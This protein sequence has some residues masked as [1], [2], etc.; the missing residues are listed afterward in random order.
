[1]KLRKILFIL[2]SSFLY[3]SLFSQ[4][5]D[6]KF[7]NI[8]IEDGLSHNNVYTIAQDSKGFMWIGTQSGL[9][10]YNGYSINSY[11]YSAE[12]SCSIIS[13][14][15]GKLMFDSKNRLW[16]GTYR[17]GISLYYPHEDKVVQFLN[18]PD[19]EN[20]LAGN[21]IRALVE[22]KE[23]N[24]W[25][26]TAE[27]GLSMYNETTNNF[28]NYTN[29]AENPNSLVSNNIRGL[30][31]DIEGNIWIGTTV[32][33]SKF[34]LKD[35]TFTN[36]KPNETN[37]NSS[38]SD[39]NT[40]TIYA[41]KSGNVWIGTRN[42]GLNKYNIKTKAFEFFDYNSSDSTSISGSRIQCIFEDSFGKIWIG[43]YEGGVCIYN[44]EAKN[45]IRYQHS[46]DNP[47]SLCYDKIETIIEDKS[48][49]L[50]IGTRGGG[51][52]IVDL[53][54]QKF[55]NLIHSNQNSIPEGSVTAIAIENENIIWIGTVNGLCHY[56]K[57]TNEFLTF[58]E[59]EN[60]PNSLSNSRIRSLVSDEKG[61]LWVGTYQGGINKIEYIDNNYVITRYQKDENNANSLLS[62]QTNILKKDKSGSIWIG[63]SS[64]LTCMKFEND[65]PVYNNYVPDDETEGSISNKYVT[66]IFE[67]LEG[68]LWIGT[69]SGLDKYD[70]HKNNFTEYLNTTA[71]ETE[72]E[73]NAINTIA[74]AD[75]G[76][77]WIGT[78][79]SGFYHFNTKTGIYTKFNDNTFKTSNISAI[80]QDKNNN[81]WIS[82]STGISVFNIETQ[83]FTYYGISDGLIETGFNRNS[84]AITINGDMYFGNISGV[85]FIQPEKIQLN[86]HIPQIVLTEL[87]I[88]NTSFF[89]N[90]N[91]FCS[92]TPSNLKEIELSY[93]DYVISFEFASLD[94]TD[95][96][97]NNYRYKMEGF[98]DEW[99]DF[100][101]KRYA[102]FTNL[103]SGEYILKIQG[104]NNDGIWSDENT[105]LSIKVT[106]KPPFWE[107]WWF[108]AIVAAIIILSIY[109][110]I[111]WREKKLRKE[112]DI[113]EQKVKER[114]EEV[115]AQKE[116]LQ[117][118]AKALEESNIELEK[119]SIV[120]RETDN[121]VTI[122]DA[123][124]NFEWVNQGFIR[125]YGWRNLEQF[126]AERGENILIGDFCSSTKEAVKQCIKEKS[127]TYSKDEVKGANDKLIWLQTTWTPILDEYNNITK[128]IAIDSDITDV[129]KAEMEIFAQKEVL[130]EQNLI[131]T[132]HN[133]NIKSSIKYAQTIQKAIL[134]S[135]TNFEKFSEYFI[136][137]YPKDIV[138]GDFYWYHQTEKYHFVVVSDCT[139]HG[140]PGA[141]MSM[142]GSRLL[143]GI[144]TERK[145]YE[146]GQILTLLNNELTESLNQKESENR[147][148]MDI[149]L[150]RIE[151]TSNKNI[152]IVF[153]GSKRELIYYKADEKQ[154]HRLKGSR[155][156]IGGVLK[157]RTEDNFE[158][159]TIALQKGDI[160][161][162]T[163][164]GYIDQCNEDRTRFGTSRF[165]KDLEKII[166]KPLQEQQSILENNLN[167]WQTNSLQRDDI[168]MLAIKL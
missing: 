139:G 129:K 164:D 50:W 102:T 106:V 9:D 52:S 150:V 57:L 105:S 29:D 143:D 145:N 130:E 60:N 155:K 90:Q 76:N 156:R 146:P 124:G 116:E 45:F 26:G 70:P 56:N 158:N 117:V 82:T 78:D 160:I 13:S 79:G 67:D 25:I 22:D 154:I 113:L 49:N 48:Q 27:N 88:F 163:T 21:L 115:Q 100:G 1:M 6:L 99:I 51:I 92:L 95:P 38:I 34:S 17:G 108:Y 98:N 35:K 44:Q 46:D 96:S 63:T 126:K 31:C 42:K 165:V 32:G 91:S 161:Y 121:A 168:T 83:K 15:F 62:D 19:D 74:L 137:Y 3:T 142:I 72:T 75:S 84:A 2:L 107:T 40:Q 153:E 166:E 110:Y 131:I 157:I 134:P 5:K 73:V 37:P 55:T 77:L 7:N 144:I 30:A 4:V 85:T 149:C 53:K 71:K 10:K 39:E 11:F 61:V 148:G 12:D 81:L 147:D 118:Q 24:I 136:I 109:S 69:S 23:G 59:D 162:L 103:P 152:E 80:L 94:F 119:L 141:F 125:L 14:N 123:E 47:N 140:V 87:K 65:I 68:N 18:N 104:T 28:T 159:K 122:M 43:T 114:T 127:T 8:T 133:E 54:P 16:I 138:S 132:A 64:G 20:S 101:T 58:I 33:V 89:T 41:D 97:K 120:A 167:K 36:Y 135:K 86:Q 128:I 111:K 112:K 151:K 93:K 66:D